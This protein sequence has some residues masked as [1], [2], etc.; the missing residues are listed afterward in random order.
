M[1][2]QGK[3]SIGNPDISKI[4]L[5]G[6]KMNFLIGLKLSKKNRS[7][8]ISKRKIMI[9]YKFSLNPLTKL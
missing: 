8:V 9:N 4:E 2:S 1:I 6:V 5:F 3:E 7:Y